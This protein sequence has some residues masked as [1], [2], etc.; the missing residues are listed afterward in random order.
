MTERQYKTWLRL[1]LQGLAYT[2]RLKGGRLT[3]EE[4]FD[5]LVAIGREAEERLPQQ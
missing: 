4:I 3:A 5:R 2:C 1:R